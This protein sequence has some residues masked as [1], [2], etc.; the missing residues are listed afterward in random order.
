MDE[1]T[2]RKTAGWMKWVCMCVTA[3]VHQVFM[4]LSASVCICMCLCK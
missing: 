1:V 4:C 3:Y 2:D